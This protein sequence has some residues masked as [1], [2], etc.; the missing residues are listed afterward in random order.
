MG[1]RLLRAVVKSIERTSEW[2][3]KVVSWLMAILVLEVR[4]DVILRYAFNQP[5]VW[6]YDISYM[7]AGTII[8]LAAAWVLLID[9]H[10][11]L[12]VISNK[13]PTRLRLYLDLIF[14]VICFF[15]LIYLL[16]RHSINVTVT[17]VS[18]FERSNVSYWRTP[19]WPF[20]I[21]I[22][23]GFLLLLV[24]GVASFVRKLFLLMGREL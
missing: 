12:D 3:G 13:F 24:Q 6:S 22:T 11:S 15:P 9:G 4:Y 5:T 1:R 16:L 20:R 18:V 21:I 19:I 10:I 7:L 8:M 2:T 14:F 17:G 23:A